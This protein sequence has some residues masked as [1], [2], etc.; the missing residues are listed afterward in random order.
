MI[1]FLI[2]EK[3]IQSQP[4]ILILFKFVSTLRK[5]PIYKTHNTIFLKMRNVDL[6]E[7][8]IKRYTAS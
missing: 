2:Y 6:Q 4:I 7:T 5:N 3:Y 1:L 8:S